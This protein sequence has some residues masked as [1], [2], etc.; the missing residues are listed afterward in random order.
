MIVFKKNKF[1]KLAYAAN[2]VFVILQCLLIIAKMND[3]L[4][5][6]TWNIFLLDLLLF[7]GCAWEYAKLTFGILFLFCFERS[8]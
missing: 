3:S 6:K 8:F 1:L 7:E 2:I 5:L 4:E